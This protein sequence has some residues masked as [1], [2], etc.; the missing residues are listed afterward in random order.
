MDRSPGRIASVGST[1]YNDE[2]LVIALP[3]E[4]QARRRTDGHDQPCSN[5]HIAATSS[6]YR[7][8][9]TARERTVRPAN[10]QFALARADSPPIRPCLVLKAA[11]TTSTKSP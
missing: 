4:N 3:D 5:P 11:A 7:A 1:P 9:K 8:N 2:R 6:S 10:G